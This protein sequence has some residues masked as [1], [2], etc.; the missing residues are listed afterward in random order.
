MERA[1]ALLDRA[2]TRN[3]PELLLQAH[4]GNWA[5][6]LNTGAF[7]RCCEHVEAGLS[8][9]HQGDY[10][11]LARTYANHDPK[12]CAHGARAQ[13]YWLQGKLKRAMEDER[14]A[15]SWADEIDHVGSRV[16]ALGLTLLH[17]VYRREHREVF[18][19]AG[20]LI[21]FTAEH[22]VADHEGAG[23]VFQGWV[24]ATQSD[25]LSGLRMLE[26]GFARQQEVATSE[27]FSVYYCLQ[28]EALAAAGQPDKA[29]ENL[30]RERPQFD[31]S[32]QRIWLPEMLRMTGE[33][34]LAADF[35]AASKAMT[36]FSEAAEMADAQ[37]APMLGLRIAMSAARLDLRLGTV[38]RA[39]I[40]VTSAL[41]K[42]V[43]PDG[44][45]DVLDAKRL[46]A[47]AEMKLRRTV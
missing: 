5:C 24:V 42:V 26:E 22:G 31:R 40:R 47:E 33:M 16:H 13:A 7:E 6:S 28:A 20:E 30:L 19:R 44:S 43:E 41:G 32:G 18:E 9:Y 23:L 4:H 25:A 35:G 36:Y 21:A 15:L 2:V 45:A 12:V 11:H 34:T 14:Q 46:L 29:L 37:G 1:T 38:D 17:R 3:D 39:A 27:D 10:R 8:I